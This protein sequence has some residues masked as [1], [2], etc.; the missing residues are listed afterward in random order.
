LKALLHFSKAQAG[1]LIVV[2]KIEQ[3]RLTTKKK[4][5]KGYKNQK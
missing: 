4:A 3:K 2:Y 5:K 1:S